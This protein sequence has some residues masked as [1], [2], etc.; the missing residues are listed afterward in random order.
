MSLLVVLGQREHLGV[1]ARPL[2]VE[3][4]GDLLQAALVPAV[5]FVVRETKWAGVSLY[6]A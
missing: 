2:L 6:R 5:K 3:R 4:V 1:R